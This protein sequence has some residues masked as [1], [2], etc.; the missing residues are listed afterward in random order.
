M[1]LFLYFII[2]LLMCNNL[3]SKHEEKAIGVEEFFQ[4]AINKYKN[5]QIFSFLTFSTLKG[6]IYGKGIKKVES[7]CCYIFTSEKSL[8]CLSTTGKKNLYKGNN[9]IQKWS[10]LASKIL[11]Q[12]LNIAKTINYPDVV[13]FKKF[14]DFRTF[15]KTITIDNK[16]SKVN[17][18]DCYKLVCMTKN[19]KSPRQLVFFFAKRTFLLQK[20]IVPFNIKGKNCISE[21]T[22]FYDLNDKSSLKRKYSETKNINDKKIIFTLDV[23]YNK[24]FLNVPL[25]AELLNS[26]LNKDDFLKLKEYFTFLRKKYIK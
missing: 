15:F 9:G 3:I 8:L 19:E 10:L 14:K 5:K 7:S 16:I 12:D 26:P 24:I 1:K 2:M 20:S 4:S 22:Y 13:F 17:D 11:K 23:V 21:T 25:K 18:L 6:I